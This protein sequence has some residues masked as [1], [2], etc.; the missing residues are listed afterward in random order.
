MT[1]M[2]AWTQDGW[3]PSEQVHLA[4]DDWGFVQGAVIVDRLRTCNAVPLDVRSHVDR[5]LHSCAAVGIQLPAGQDLE[6]LVG[7]CA[8]RNRGAFE[9]QDFS[10]VLVATPGRVGDPRGGPTVIVYPRAIAWTTLAD[11]FECGQHLIIPEPRNVPTACWSPQ[12]KTRARLQYYLADRQA[13]EISGSAG[14]VL[15]DL[16]QHLTETSAANLIVVENAKTMVSPP[17]DRILNGVSLARTLRL[18]QGVGLEVRCEPISVVRAQAATELLL[19][20]SSGCLWPAAS[21]EGVPFPSVGEGEVFRQLS[22]LWMDEIGLDYVQ[23][24]KTLAGRN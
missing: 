16:D 22:G 6:S 23:Q 12:I 15:L 17:L 19:C 21:L 9:G 20:G 13:A 2:V 5:F 24:A 14:A 4:L 7:Q 8:D 18:A 11:W 10:I 1:A 3:L